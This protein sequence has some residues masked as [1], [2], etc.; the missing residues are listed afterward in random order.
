MKT[1]HQH[2]RKKYKWTAELQRCQHHT[3]WKKTS[4]RKHCGK[5]KRARALQ[6]L[7]QSAQ[8]SRQSQQ[9]SFQHDSNP[10]LAAYRQHWSGFWIIHQKTPLVVHT[11]GW[12]EQIRPLWQGLKQLAIDTISKPPKPEG[13][14]AAMA[15]R[16]L[17]PNMQSLW[18]H[19]WEV[20]RRENWRQNGF[21]SE[22]GKSFRVFI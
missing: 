22:L 16:S 8:E 12:L 9:L 14:W 3:D 1:N 2:K 18:D 6:N 19:A 15:E 4:V 13:I 11:N 7:L 5:V 20:W 17:N 10:Y 21:K